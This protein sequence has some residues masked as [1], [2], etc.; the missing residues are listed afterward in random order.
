LTFRSEPRS[1][2]RGPDDA[3]WFVD[4]G[5]ARLGRVAANGD[6]SYEPV[7]QAPDALAK[8]PLNG[9]WYAYGTTV[10]KL[11]DAGATYTLPSAVNSLT[12][13]PDDTL[14]AA[15]NGGAVR[16]EPGG[17]PS[18][19]PTAADGLAIVQGPDERMWM[20]LDRPPYLVK[21]AV[22]PRATSVTVTPERLT[23]T[24]DPHGVPTTATAETQQADGSW[25]ELRSLNAGTT[26]ATVVLDISGPA[27]TR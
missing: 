6:L 19:V 7:E 23:A 4:R 9:L 10:R 20:T 16:I 27:G 25:R 5:G 1:I 8:G 12:Q 18:F 2:T 15:V 14:W 3:L 22:P 11:G 21:I 17:A 24:V 13:G 26:P